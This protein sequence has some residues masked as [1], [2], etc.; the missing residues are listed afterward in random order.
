MSDVTDGPV[1]PR[2][3]QPLADRTVP[4]DKSVSRSDVLGTIGPPP[5][6]PNVAAAPKVPTQL[7]RE[8]ILNATASCLQE[9]GYDGTT[10]RRIAKELD[11][12]VGSIYRYF[13]DKRALL[14][15][16]VQRRFEP[17]LDR[18]EQ[19]APADA[20]ANLYGQIAAEQPELYRLM[21]WLS[22]IGKT[23]LGNTLPAAVQKIIDGWAKQFD[24]R[25][26]AETYWAL[27]H[28]AIMQ[29]R[30]ADD[31]GVPMTALPQ[32]PLEA[33]DLHTNGQA[34]PPTADLVAT[35]TN[36]QADH[37]PTA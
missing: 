37:T 19:G 16:V 36:G 15:A 22:S 9:L 23:T 24:D 32:Q 18:I 31:L 11:C 21:F 5:V 8:Q 13:D 3:P 25:R 30:R 7:S 27:L 35:S 28:G 26:A 34:D 33:A 17:V 6:M 10:I 1:N 2:P 14:A 20:S 12:A 4:P 29:G